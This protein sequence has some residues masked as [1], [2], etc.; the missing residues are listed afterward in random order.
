MICIDTGLWSVSGRAV[1]HEMLDG[2]A[3]DDNEYVI[4]GIA[5]LS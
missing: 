2:V 1:K 4:F 3:E 5:I